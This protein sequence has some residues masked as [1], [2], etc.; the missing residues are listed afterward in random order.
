MLPWPHAEMVYSSP[1][2]V[3]QGKAPATP[4]N[5]PYC[6]GQMSVCSLGKEHLS[7]SLV[8]RKMAR[9]SRVVSSV[10]IGCWGSHTVTKNIRVGLSSGCWPLGILGTGVR[11]SPAQ[12]REKRWEGREDPGAQQCWLRTEEAGKETP[13]QRGASQT[14]GPKLDNP[15][16]TRDQ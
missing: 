1:C 2:G 13:G 9:P 3:G 15:G 6:V 14:S 5:P 10:L 11:P 12:E 16:L 4:Q 7:A 8:G